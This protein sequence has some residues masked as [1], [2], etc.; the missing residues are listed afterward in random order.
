MGVHSGVCVW[1]GVYKAQ[2]HIIY[3]CIQTVSIRCS[4]RVFVGAA[5]AVLYYDSPCVCVFVCVLQSVLIC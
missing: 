2:G 3:I 4:F 1:G 5:K